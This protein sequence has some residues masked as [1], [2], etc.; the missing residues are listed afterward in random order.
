M[1]LSIPI[2]FLGAKFFDYPI[3]FRYGSISPLTC[4]KMDIYLFKLTSK[5][6]WFSKL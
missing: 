2:F 3:N 1:S 6:I 5:I 4:I